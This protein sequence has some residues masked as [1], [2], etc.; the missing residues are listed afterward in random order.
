[1][2]LIIDLIR[3]GEPIGGSMYRGQSI[4]HPLSEK[5][6]QQMWRGVGNEQWKFILS[7]PLIR[8]AQFSQLLAVQQDI[9]YVLKNNLKEIGFGEWEGKNKTELKQTRLAE[10]NAF[11]QNPLLNTPPKAE[12]WTDFSFRIGNVYQQILKQYQHHHKIL[13]V[14]H[15]GVIRAMVHH[16]MD[17]PIEQ[18]VTTEIKNGYITRLYIRQAGNKLLFLNEHL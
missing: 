1:M 9:K 16:I 12:N 6:W 3:H 14:C 4:D 13:I 10:F 7:S 15:A 18:M 8:C 17:I 5:G 2:S 11:Y